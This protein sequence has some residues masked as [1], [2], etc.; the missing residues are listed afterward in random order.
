MCL[1]ALV[2]NTPEG[3]TTLMENVTQLRVSQNGSSLFGVDLF[4]SQLELRDH[5]LVEIDFEHGVAL[6]APTLEVSDGRLDCPRP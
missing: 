5:R 3:R 4:G 1:M 2:T 6:V